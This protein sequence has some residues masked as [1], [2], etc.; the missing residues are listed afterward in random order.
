M[1]EVILT[2]PYEPALFLL[3][4]DSKFMVY[5]IIVWNESTSNDTIGT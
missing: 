1:F 2:S 3:E 4:V 5:I